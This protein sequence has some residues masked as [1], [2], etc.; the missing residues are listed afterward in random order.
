[1]IQW[2]LVICVCKCFLGAL[3]HFL[4]VNDRTTGGL[5]QLYIL[6]SA[7]TG[8]DSPE[9]AGWYGLSWLKT[10]NH[11]SLSSSHYIPLLFLCQ[12]Q[13]CVSFFVTVQ[14]QLIS[15]P[16]AIYPSLQPSCF[17]SI[18]ICDPQMTLRDSCYLKH[19]H[20]SSSRQRD[21]EG[22]KREGVE[23]RGGDPLGSQVLFSCCA[24]VLCMAL[25]CIFQG[26]SGHGA[27]YIYTHKMVLSAC[28]QL[29]YMV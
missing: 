15:F 10:V 14:S 18:I 17:P 29:H 19:M 21:G 22:G 5:P 23:W 3:L 20:S 1:M 25:L 2:L 24:H 27:L 16:A 26:P 8:S 6:W 28:S 13:K 7:C 12:A 9:I 4:E 11:S